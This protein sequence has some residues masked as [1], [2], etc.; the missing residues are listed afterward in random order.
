MSIQELSSLLLDYLIV[1]GSVGGAVAAIIGGVKKSHKLAV[2]WREYRATGNF[3]WDKA[4][5]QRDRM[6]AEL[7]RIND[8]EN[9]WV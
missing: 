8:K 2:R 6:L 9:L 7:R 1:A 5:V 3:E 4:E